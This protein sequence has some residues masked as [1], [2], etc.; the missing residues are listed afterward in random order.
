M[1]ILVFRKFKQ[2]CNNG[3]EMQSLK[4]QGISMF[5]QIITEN[6]TIVIS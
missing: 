1:T 2:H 5:I 6:I 4:Q 3:K